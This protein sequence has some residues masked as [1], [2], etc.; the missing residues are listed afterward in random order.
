M[1]LIYLATRNGMDAETALATSKENGFAWDAHPP[2]KQVIEQ[3]IDN[4]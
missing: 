1:A 2:I 3:Y 4:H